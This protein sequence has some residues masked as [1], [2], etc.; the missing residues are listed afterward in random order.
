MRHNTKWTVR[1]SASKVIHFT[2]REDAMAA[3]YEYGYAIY[4]PIYGD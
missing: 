1:V 2:N 4:P 3:A